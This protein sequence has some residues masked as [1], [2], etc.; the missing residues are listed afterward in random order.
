MFKLKTPFSQKDISKLKIGDKVLLNG[1]V[2]TARD[3][4]HEFLLKSNFKGM[5]N[6]VIYHCGPIVKNSKVIAAGPTTSSRLN[7]FTP[8][9]IKKYKIKAIVGK[10]GMDNSVLNALKGKAVYFS[11]IGGAAVLYAEKIQIK[12]VYKKEL[13]M[14]E[15]VWELEVKDFPVIVTMDSKGNSLYNKVYR[16]SKIIFQK[17]I[18][19]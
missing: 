4:A 7:F 12:N 1:T 19:D 8:K 9:L 2:F 14:T 3:K 10:G 17:L 11:A 18:K 5:R 13:G 15:A 6:S 16:K